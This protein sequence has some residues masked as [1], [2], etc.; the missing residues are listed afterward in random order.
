MLI[1]LL[2]DTH[3]NTSWVRYALDKFSR[4]GVTTILQV[5]DFG[6]YDKPHGH[7]FLKSVRL[8]L[9]KHEQTMYVVPGN[10]EDYTYINS[11]PVNEDGWQ[12]L[13][14]DRILLAP[15]GHRWSWDYASFVGLGGAPSVD[16]WY[17]TTVLKGTT[18]WAEEAITPEDVALTVAGGYA[19]VMV[20]HDAPFVPQIE[21]HIAGNPMGFTDNDLYYAYEGRKLMQKAFEGVQPK[22]FLHGHYHTRINSTLHVPSAPFTRDV[23]FTTHVLGLCCDGQNF[24]LGSLDT[25]TLD[26]VHWDI[27]QDLRDYMKGRFLR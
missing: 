4:E 20:G 27:E 17:R 12:H 22:V 21:S 13:R 14:K 6:I 11:I 9:E 7:G 10:H 25:E 2:G 1:G 24:S 8:A 26:A 16:R 19:D 5:G 23:A 15:R 18:W 3:G